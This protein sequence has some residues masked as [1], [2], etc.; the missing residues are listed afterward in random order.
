MAEED[1]E[2]QEETAETAPPAR[3]IKPISLLRY[4]PLVFIVI[5]LQ[6]GAAYYFIENYWMRSEDAS[7]SGLEEWERPRVIPESK[8]P[9]AIVAMGEF[10]INPRFTEA[11]LLVSIEVTLAVAPDDTKSEIEDDTKIDQIRDA[12]IYELSFATPEEM[13]NRRGRQI[14]K[15]RLIKRLNDLL[16]EGQVV[17]VF[18]PKLIIQAL[19]GYKGEQTDLK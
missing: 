13:N 9:E 11:R 12:I 16:Y 10:F 18:F 5:L 3:K 19:P 2:P 4:L 15:E 7:L 6:A 8:S 17:D 1:V 14:V